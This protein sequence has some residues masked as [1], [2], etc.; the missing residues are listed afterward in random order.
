MNYKV[1]DKR[2][3][4]EPKEVCRVC[5]SEEIHTTKYN[6][7]TMKCIKYLREKISSLEEINIIEFE[8]EL[9]NIRASN[10]WRIELEF[11]GIWSISV[12]DKETH[13]LLGQ[14][15]ATSL[16]GILFVLQKPFNDSIWG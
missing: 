6:N 9:N 14:T 10:G 7:P 15:G 12:Y 3:E 8:K 2:E 11:S 16:V 4:K 5:S 1:I 13:E